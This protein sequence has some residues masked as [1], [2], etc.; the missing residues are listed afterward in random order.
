MNIHKVS[1]NLKLMLK[2]EHEAEMYL[3]T[4]K[5]LDMRETE[6]RMEILYNQLTARERKYFIN[7]AVR[8]RKY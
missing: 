3:E 2:L 5:E 4:G 8:I 1:N 6:D 7:Y